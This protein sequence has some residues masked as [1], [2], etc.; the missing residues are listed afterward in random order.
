MEPWLFSKTF[1]TTKLSCKGGW[2]FLNV[3]TKQNHPAYQA[4]SVIG[5]AWLPYKQPLR[6][7]EIPVINLFNCACI[8]LRN[9]VKIIGSYIGLC[10]KYYGS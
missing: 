10:N 8:L 9:N 6:K 1:K 5:T 3:K 7:N 4:V 2:N